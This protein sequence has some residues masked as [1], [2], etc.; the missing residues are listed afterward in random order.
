MKAQKHFLIIII[1][2]SALLR[3]WDLAGFPTGFNADEAALGYNAY[4]I[5]KTG[6]DEYGEVLPL[7]FKSFG[8]YKPGF[9]VYLDIPFIALFGLNELAVR[10][11]SALLGITTVLLVYL[12]ARKIFDSE[13]V[14][15]FSAL[16]LAVSPWHIHFSRGAWETNVAT[17]FITLGVW[18]FIK[19]LNS[20]MW[21]FISLVAF[22]ASAYTYQSPRLIVPLLLLILL[23]KYWKYLIPRWKSLIKYA[24]VLFILTLPIV[25]Q[26]VSGAGTARFAGLSIFSDSGTILRSNELRSEH[27]NI[28]GIASL[29][30]HNKVTA[31]TFSFLGHYL[32]HFTPEFLFIDGDSLIR[33]K[34]PDVGQFYLIESIFL[35]V[36][37]FF[38]IKLRIKYTVILLI[39]ILVGPVA[40][41]LTYQTPHALRSLNIVI[42]LTILMGFGLDKMIGAIKNLTS[43]IETL[44]IRKVLLIATIS[45]MTIFLFFEVIHYLQS[46]YIHYPKR[47]PLAWEHGF[48]EMVQKLSQYENKYQK[49]IITDRYDQPYILTLFYKKYD[50]AKFQ[51]QAILSERDK[52]NFGTIRSFD[53]YEFRKI[54]KEDLNKEN[55]LL[56]GTP[57][58]LSKVNILDKVEFP[59][60]ETA[61]VFIKK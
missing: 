53:N 52:F 17:F 46:Y 41:A 11:P 2:L 48:K 58:E 54:E 47:Y 49:I 6:K 37:I 10:L 61:F 29:F 31:Y 22:I 4:S 38:A 60:G 34:V 33:N 3:L 42:P 13:N 45:F 8:D 56:I 1:I 55:V 12:L 32:D 16:L 5:L 40:S 26:F 30:M 24:I 44:Y 25:F 43:K 7:S 27:Q 57:E 59:N 35:A 28:V 39:W 18:T 51:K 14:G 9:Y 23:T 15:L 36:G 50:P 20:N 21:L 19:G